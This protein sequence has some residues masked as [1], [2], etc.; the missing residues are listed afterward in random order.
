MLLDNLAGGFDAKVKA[1]ENPVLVAV[2]WGVWTQAD[3]A[4]AS[5]LEAS[6]LTRIK[7]GEQR[8]TKGHRA[9]L[10]WALAGRVLR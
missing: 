9:A 8:M 4:K 2:A 10:L 3:L 6:T 5:G 7:R 1:G